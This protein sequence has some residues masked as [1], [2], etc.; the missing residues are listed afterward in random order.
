LFATTVPTWPK[1]S[2]ARVAPQPVMK[3]G[4]SGF[5]RRNL[6]T[7]WAHWR[8]AS[9]VTLHVFTTIARGMCGRNIAAIFSHSNAL[10]RHPKDKV[11]IAMVLYIAVVI[12]AK[13]GTAAE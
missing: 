13:A 8:S 1:I 7:A 12:P 9:A 5:S 2:G 4:A 10:S 6:R 11:S 3:I